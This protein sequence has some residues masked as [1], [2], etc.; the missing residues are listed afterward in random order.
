[1]KL[2]AIDHSA[3]FDVYPNE[4][5]AANPPFPEFGVVPSS[6]AHPPMDA[7]MITATMCFRSCQA[8]TK[9]VADLEVLP[10]PDL[11]S[12]TGRTRPWRMESRLPLRLIIDGYTDYFTATSM[13][14]ADQAGLKVIA[15]MWSAGREGSGSRVEDMGFPAGLERTMTADLTAKLPAGTRRIR[16]KQS[17]NLLGRGSALTRRRS[18]ASVHITEVP[19]AKCGTRFSRLPEGIRLMPASD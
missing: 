12:C 11:P 7:W 8:R 17:E 4:R 18:S 14:A 2:L 6:N 5:F 3:R 16:S 13:Y 10:S 9:Y 1:V 15:R 19:L